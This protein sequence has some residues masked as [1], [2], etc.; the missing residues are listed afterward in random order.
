MIKFIVFDRILD[1]SDDENVLEAFDASSL[2]NAVYEAR[3]CWSE[4]GAVLYM[5]KNGQMEYAASVDD[6]K[7]YPNKRKRK[8]KK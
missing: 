4:Q 7:T 3:E 5:E 8:S 1:H 6:Y 2:E